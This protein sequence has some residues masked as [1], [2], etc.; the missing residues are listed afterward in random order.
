MRK[1]NQKSLH[2]S[3]IYKTVEVFRYSGQTDETRLT[4][5]GGTLGFVPAVGVP[6]LDMD[7]AG[8][9]TEETEDTED[10]EDIRGLFSGVSSPV[11]VSLTDFLFR[12]SAVPPGSGRTSPLSAGL[13]TT[14]IG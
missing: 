10:T 6:G 7:D 9:D 13:L 11:S 8:G 3:L 4:L 12:G 2:S 1:N 5:S 14:A